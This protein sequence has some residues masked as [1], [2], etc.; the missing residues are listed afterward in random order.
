[1]LGT[2][3]L[4]PARPGSTLIR[5]FWQ[6][7]PE[8]RPWGRDGRWSRWDRASQT[9]SAQL[10]PDRPQVR[11]SQALRRPSCWPGAHGLQ[12]AWACLCPPGTYSPPSN[13]PG[14]RHSQGGSRCPHSPWPQDS[15]FPQPAVAPSGT[16]AEELEAGSCP[17]P[18]ADAQG[19]QGPPAPQRAPPPAP[20]TAAATTGPSRAFAPAQKEGASTVHPRGSRSCSCGQTPRPWQE[21]RWLS[22][23]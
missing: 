3:W 17:P 11:K 21:T 5:S 2:T 18:A 4:A 15:H 7:P 19:L 1:M 23:Q 22:T 8:P 14:R 10:D 13:T 20:S 16:G 6:H 12:T 9:L